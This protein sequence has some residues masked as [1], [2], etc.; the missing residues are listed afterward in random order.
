MSTDRGCL[1]RFREADNAGQH[2]RACLEAGR[3]AARQGNLEEARRLLRAAVQA[4]PGCS[5]AWLQLAWLTEAPRE[6][7]MLL[8]QVL[9]LEP[10]HFQARAELARLQ[11]PSASPVVTPQAPQWRTGRW[12]LG[13]LVVAAFVLLALLLWAPVARSLAGLLPTLTPPSL[14][15]PTRTPAE[16]AAQFEPKLRAAFS[17]EDWN[18]AVEI[19]DIM[20]GVDPGGEQAQRWAL[21][22]H[23]RYGQALVEAGQAVDALRQF[24]QAVALVPGDAEAQQWQQTTQLYL[25]GR[26][27]LLT[28]DWSAAIQTLTQAHEQMP[29]FGDLSARLVEAYSGYGKAALEAGDWTACIKSLTEARER[30]PGDPALVELLSTAYRQRGVA[31]HEGGQLQQAKSDLEAALALRPDDSE[32]QAHY[33]EV[34]YVLFPP[35]RIEI[36]I[37]AQHFYAWQ[38][39]TLIYSFP[40]STGLP[41]RDTAAGKFKVLDK[42]PMAYSS[43]WRLQMPYWLGIYYVGNIENGIHALP[44]RPDGTVMWA[45]LLGQKASYGCVILSTEAARLVYEWAEI[46]TA[47]DIHY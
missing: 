21:E 42:M 20:L 11:A 29:D 9:S 19:A 14:P 40:T 3:R 34:M 1:E 22:A 25:A 8:Q 6:R 26:E 47:V 46:G 2:A 10:D 17:G 41:G 30:L 31:A 43:I 27:A 23:V 4:D 38:G 33:D 37:S 44:I 45:G 32:A 16:V 24:D 15:T 28:G 12:V 39:D 5:E 35:K 36:D 18:R 13:L 7:K